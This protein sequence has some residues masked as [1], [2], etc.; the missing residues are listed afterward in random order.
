MIKPRH[1]SGPADPALLR[2]AVNAELW[3]HNEGAG[4]PMVEIA[5]NPRVSDRDALELYTAVEAVAFIECVVDSAR[6]AFGAEFALRADRWRPQRFGR[7]SDSPATRGSRF[8][9]L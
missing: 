3:E 9:P 7:C 6:T 8:R 4:K 1:G 5:Q 2:R